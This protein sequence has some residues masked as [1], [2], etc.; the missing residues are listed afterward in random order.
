LYFGGQA[1]VDVTSKN[2]PDILP[3][4]NAHNYDHIYDW[5]VTE[6]EP[7]YAGPKDDTLI[8]Q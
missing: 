8:L 6:G 7:L 3:L 2:A 4:Y 1:F 5:Q